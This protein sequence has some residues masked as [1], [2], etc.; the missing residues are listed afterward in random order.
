MIDLD[1][2]KWK[3]EHESQ[4]KSKQTREIKVQ[5]ENGVNVQKEKEK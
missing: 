4:K 3:K 1:G 2:I 5:L